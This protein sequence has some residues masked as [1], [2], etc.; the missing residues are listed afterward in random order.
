M[1]DSKDM[2]SNMRVRDA[3]TVFKQWGGSLSETF[4]MLIE[5]F[6]EENPEEGMPNDNYFHALFYTDYM[7]RSTKHHLRMLS[8]ANGDGFLGILKKSFE[9]TLQTITKNK[10]FAHII[11][12]DGGITTFLKS[13]MDKY[14][15]FKITLATL[16]SDKDLPHTIVSDDYMVREENLHEKVKD[17]SD[18]REISAT[19]YFDNSDR[20]QVA[21][22]SFDATWSYL[23]G[24]MND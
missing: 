12:I 16:V 5:S 14:P 15:I 17:V 3:K 11:L 22:K 9:A 4:D 10:G 23:N 19:V 2:S 7:F 8:G 24:E 18:I 1:A 20:A 13:M 21:A 6:K